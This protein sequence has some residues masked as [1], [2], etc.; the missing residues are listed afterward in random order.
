[1][2]QKQLET[3]G[4]RIM[5]LMKKSGMSSQELATKIDKHFTTVDRIIHSVTQNPP[6]ATLRKIANALNTSFEYLSTGEGEEVLQSK[7]FANASADPYR[8]YA[9]QRLE[10]E[11]ETWKEKYE[12]V[13]N[14]FTNLLERVPLGKFDP[15][16]EAARKLKAA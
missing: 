14:K 13:W 11:A 15:V 1:M 12:Q 9:I 3:L 5:R 6:D 10:K 4:D 8:D 2:G 16:K 7:N